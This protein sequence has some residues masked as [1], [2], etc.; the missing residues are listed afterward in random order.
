MLNEDKVD[1]RRFKSANVIVWRRVGTFVVDDV[2]G[3]SPPVKS[4][5]VMNAFQFSTGSR[6]GVSGDLSESGAFILFRAADAAAAAAA[7][8]LIR[9]LYWLV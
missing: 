8:A 4:S 1:D 9:V 7:A 6:Q 5:S 3:I 2:T